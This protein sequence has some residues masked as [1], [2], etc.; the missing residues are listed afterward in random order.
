MVQVL[1]LMQHLH[2]A[3]D[4]DITVLEISWHFPSDFWCFASHSAM[5]YSKATAIRNHFVRNLA[6]EMG[7]F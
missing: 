1:Q 2:H 4:S 7:Q 6:L 3:W 5:R